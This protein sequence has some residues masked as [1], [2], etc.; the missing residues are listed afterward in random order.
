[1]PKAQGGDSTGLSQ[2]PRKIPCLTFHREANQTFILQS[3]GEEI[4]EASPEGE[5]FPL[6]FKHET[7]RCPFSLGW[8]CAARGG[9]MPRWRGLT[10][11]SL[12]QGC[13]G[14]AARTACGSHS[15]QQ[16]LV[17]STLFLI[18]LPAPKQ[19][20]GICYLLGSD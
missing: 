16:T 19:L 12:G 11:S 1:M 14:P 4:A 13:G 20:Q 3:K 7:L 17:S 6:Y 10:F 8:G 9:E 15:H 2:N 18:G 5:R